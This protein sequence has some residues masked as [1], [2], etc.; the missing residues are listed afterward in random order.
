[1][2]DLSED[3]FTTL[4]PGHS[5]TSVINI[6]A[7]HEV[8]GGDYAVS[9]D[10]A[11]PYAATNTTEIEGSVAY[12]SNLLTLT[13]S[14]DDIAVVPRAV[15]VLDRRTILTSCSGTEDTEHRS[16]LSQMV[17]LATTVSKAASSGS[18][19]KF[20]EFFKTTSS[21]TRQNV[22]AR[23]AAISREAASTTSGATRYYCDDP[24]AYCDS[25]TLA[26]T[27]PSHNLV[28]N[29]PLYYS[30]PTLS[31]VC[32]QQDQVTTALH[33]FTHAGAV[34]SPGTQDYAYGY[35]ASTRL[36]SAQAV[37]N[38]DTYALYANGEFTHLEGTRAWD[39]C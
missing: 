35:S 14:E 29:C 16:A 9:T 34:Y 11:I 21:A 7:L 13:L 4:E 30:L 17:N 15:P 32:R 37:L 36:S 1:M 2:H 26:Y 33:E 20:S 24:Y 31:R 3:A 28:V 6:A 38:A 12:E 18:A 22:A 23:Y 27:L 25:Y 39:L 8:K 5:F 19:T 10:G